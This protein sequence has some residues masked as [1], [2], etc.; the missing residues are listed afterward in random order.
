VLRNYAITYPADVAGMVLVDAAFEGERVG[1]GGGK[2]IR[3]G[4]GA[5]GLAIPLAREEMKK[6]D[7]PTSLPQLPPELGQTLDPMYKVLPAAEQKLQLWAQSQA[8][9]YDAESSQLEWS[10]EYFSKWLAGP[11]KGVMGA[12]PLIVLTRSEGGYGNDADVPAAQ[13]E[14]ERKEGQ[15]KLVALSSNSKQT[16]VHS[17]HNMELEAPND[18][19]RAIRN[20]VDTVRNKS[21]LQ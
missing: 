17:G 20:V 14:R 4:D 2:T 16:I 9:M 13:W 3:L 10:G 5:K 8:I 15:A 7:R 11:Q 1:I 6:E 12:I 18:V 21:K 19:T